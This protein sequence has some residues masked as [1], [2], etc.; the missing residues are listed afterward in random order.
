MIYV[1]SPYTHQDISV[2][3]ARYHKA[4]D[5]TAFLLKKEWWCYSPIVHCHEMAVKFDL[6][7]DFGFW[8]RYNWHMLL[9]A[10]AFFVLDIDGWQESKGVAEEFEFAKH[11]RQLKCQLWHDRGFG[12]YGVDI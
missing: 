6:P 10:S 1:A 2:M 11:V 3:E 12:Y 5:L 7:R 9:Q 8:K 4:M